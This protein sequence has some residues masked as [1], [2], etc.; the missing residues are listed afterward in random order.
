[1]KKNFLT[2]AAMAVV[3]FFVST[4]IA[5]AADISFSGHIRTRWEVNE[6]GNN[7]GNGNV[8]ATAAAR[9][10]AGQP[11]TTNSFNN[12]PDDFINSSVRLAA[13]ANF[14]DKTSAFIQMQSIRTWGAGAGAGNVGSGNASAAV[15]DGDASVGVHQAYFTMKDFGSLPLAMDAK[16][17]RQE[18]ILDGHRLFGNTIW[19]M[20]M[21]THDAIRL[22][23]AHDNMTLNLGYI[24]A[25]EDG[26]SVDSG[27]N[28]DRDVYLAHLNV[29]GIL[30]GAFSGYFV[31]DENTPASGAFKGD[32]E[33]ITVGGR[34]AGNMFGLNYRGEYYYQFG[35]ADNQLD[36]GANATTNAD[37]DAYMFGL[38]V[39]KAFKNVGM[40]PS[41]TLWYDYLSGT[42][43]EDQRTQDWSSF[44][45]VFDTGHKFYGL[46]DVFLGVG[47]GTA[48]GTQGLGLQDTAIKTKLSPMPGWTL[49]MDYHWFHTA[50]GISANTATT[51]IT[52][53]DAN[54]LGNDLGTELDITA[55]NKYNDNTKIII[56][57]SNFNPSESFVE[58]KNAGNGSAPYGSQDA[59]WAY[60]MFDVRF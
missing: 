36:A 58:L 8:G 31:Y 29:K 15:S 57:Y 26:R 33:V 3:S 23:H 32:N 48:A 37:R 7:G 20:G 10:A 13:K 28:G 46:I 52:G 11:V 45:T 12:N 38:R 2:V 6:Q 5:K 53:A 25:Q 39:G 44:N 34:Q 60:V 22:T 14:S 9:A 4:E 30:G 40:K 42:T 43:D 56:G 54:D 55:V 18:I 24:L 50:E 1:M 51:G 41:L 27:D 35:S 19:T 47:G 17:G 49:K 21:Q 16:V 59:N